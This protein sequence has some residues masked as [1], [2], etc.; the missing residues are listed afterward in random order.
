MPRSAMPQSV[1]Q[2]LV[3]ICLAIGAGVLIFI[4]AIVA[5][6]LWEYRSDPVETTDPGEQH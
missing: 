6:A 3:W 4:A 5:Y 1:A 2:W